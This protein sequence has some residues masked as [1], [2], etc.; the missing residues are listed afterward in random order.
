[1]TAFAM[2]EAHRDDPLMVFD[3]DKAARLIK[4][5]GAKTAS[6]GLSGDWEYT[7]GCILKDGKPY[8][9]TDV[10]DGYT[11]LASTWAIPELELDEDG[12]RI[13]CWRYRSETPDWG[14]DTRWPESALGILGSD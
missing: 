11:Y 4:E 7:G 8:M 14:Y 6:A 13:D 5:R 2:G 9:N 10:G 1:M 12:E 3:W